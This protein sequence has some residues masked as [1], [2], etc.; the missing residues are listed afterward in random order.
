VPVPPSRSVCMMTKV[1][2]VS[3]EAPTMEL[4]V[5]WAWYRSP[6][7]AAAAAAARQS[8]RRLSER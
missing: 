8:Q 3:M 1:A 5:Q 2:N 7:A 4:C 6:T